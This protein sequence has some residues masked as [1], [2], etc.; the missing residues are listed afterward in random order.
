MTQVGR[1]AVLTVVAMLLACAPAPALA[2]PLAPDGP[3]LASPTGPERAPV[4][5]RTLCAEIESCVTD[6]LADDVVFGGF[7]DLAGYWALDECDRSM[8]GGA[9]DVCALHASG[10][11]SPVGD[12]RAAFLRGA[13]ELC[14]ASY[15]APGSPYRP[16][17]Q[18]GNCAGTH[19][20]GGGV[21]LSLKFLLCEKD[22]KAA[23]TQ[24]KQQPTVRGE[25]I[26]QSCAILGCDQLQCTKK[27]CT[28]VAKPVSPKTDYDSKT[29]SCTKKL[30]AAGQEIPC[31]NRGQVV[32]ECTVLLKTYAAFT[33]TCECK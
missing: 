6:S 16:R 5:P 24:A 17:L 21:D 27:V 8:V 1:F 9:F 26:K 32:W 19:A 10:T 2:G 18:H 12:D 13:A 20:V 33:C 23:E 29:V 22:Q 11:A 14:D 15:L 7:G 30:N 3:G 4:D 28:L 25:L 31:G